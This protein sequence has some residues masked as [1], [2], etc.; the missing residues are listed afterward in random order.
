MI[1][2]GLLGLKA[3]VTGGA[4]GIGRA[5]VLGLE[6]EGVTVAVVDRSES[7]VGAVRIRAS[8][9]APE[10]SDRVVEDAAEQL[11]GV[12]LLVN[13]AAIARHEPITRLSPEAWEA[14]I[15]SNL[16]A[17]VWTTRA[18]ARVMV[19]AGRGSILI[20]GST[21]VYTPAPGESIYRAS[22]AAL[23]AFAEVTAIEL[24]PHGIRVNMLTPGAVRT[25]LTA[26]MTE[27]QRAK[28]IDAI[29]LA[30]EALPEELVMT[31]ILL[32][33]DRLSPYT[34]GAEFIVDGGLRLR[35]LSP[36]SG[37]ELAALNRPQDEAESG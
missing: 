11:G 36:L 16:A 10:T 18:T 2:S 20:V 21:S 15:G 22:K 8:L 24:A 12:D 27:G 30:R 17:C 28:L 31:A 3:L 5:I 32:L 25:P 33:S 9:G 23:E 6:A 29:P 19:S 35:P 13:C 7:D 26:N 37:D 14:T 4:S 1:D 34:T